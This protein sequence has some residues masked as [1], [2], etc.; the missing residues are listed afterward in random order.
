MNGNEQTNQPSLDKSPLVQSDTPSGVSSPVKKR[1]VKKAVRKAVRKKV[2]IPK[3]ASAK[4]QPSKLDRLIAKAR[5]MY[6]DYVR[7]IELLEGSGADMSGIAN[8]RESAGQMVD[9]IGTSAEL[10]QFF[11]ICKE[12]N[13][14]LGEIQN[15]FTTD[16]INAL[17]GGVEV[18]ETQG[19]D[20]K[21]VNESITA[22]EA[23]VGNVK[24][25]SKELGAALNQIN[26]IRLWIKA[27]IE[28][29]PET[30]EEAVTE[31]ETD[32]EGDLTAD[33]GESFAE[34]VQEP[35]SGEGVL[36][37][38]EIAAGEEGMAE[39]KTVL[40]EQEEES[41]EETAEI[42]SPTPEEEEQEQKRREM[43]ELVNNAYLNIQNAQEEN[44]LKF[45]EAIE[46]VERAGNLI[47]T[48]NYDDVESLLQMVPLSIDTEIELRKSVGKKLEKCRKDLITAT[49]QGINCDEL[50]LKF[51][52]A[53]ELF[54]SS[55][56]TKANVAA[57]AMEAEIAKVV[58]DFNQTVKKIE[59]V[60]A[61][62]TLARQEEINVSE[63]IG[64]FQFLKSFMAAGEYTRAQDTLLVVNVAIMKKRKIR[65]MEEINQT[66]IIL[67]KAPEYIDVKE[68][69]AI[70]D[71]AA[72]ELEE[73]EIDEALESVKESKDLSMSIREK[74]LEL[75][76]KSNAISSRIQDLSE[77]DI[78][79][80]KIIE[81][82]SIGKEE[83]KKGDF[84]LCSEHF[85][86]ALS[87]IDSLG[88]EAQNKN[89]GIIIKDLNKIG[90]E[91]SELEEEYPDDDISELV[92]KHTTLQERF[93]EA[94]DLDDIRNLKN[95]VN[96]LENAIK[97]KKVELAKLAKKKRERAVQGE[98][99]EKVQRCR[100]LMEDIG[101][102]TDIENE[103]RSV[104][105]CISTA[106]GGDITTG[107]SSINEIYNKL[108]EKK[109]DLDIRVEI[110]L[111]GI[112]FE[113]NVWGEAK[114]KVGNVGSFPI[115]GLS[116]GLEGPF[117]MR[118]GISFDRLE[119][120]DIKTGSVAI[121]FTGVGRIP[122]DITLDFTSQPD[123]V[124]RH[125]SLMRWAEVNKETPYKLSM[126]FEEHEKKIVKQK[127]AAII[128]EKPSMRMI[129]KESRKPIKISPFDTCPV[130][131]SPVE[132]GAL[133][134]LCGCAQIYHK[135]CAEKVN[136]NSCLSCGVALFENE[137]MIMTSCSICHM[138]VWHDDEMIAHDCGEYYHRDCILAAG[139]CKNCYAP[140]DSSTGFL[141]ST[142][143]V[144]LEIVKDD[145]DH[146]RCQCG[147]AY[148]APC[149]GRLNFCIR[150][151]TNRNPS[152][153][154]KYPKV[155]QKEEEPEQIRKEEKESPVAPIVA[156]SIKPAK[157]KQEM[158]PIVPEVASTAITAAPSTPT[159]KEEEG[160][161]EKESP[162]EAESSA[163]VPAESSNGGLDDDLDSLLD[164]LEETL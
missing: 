159:T 41:V 32:I 63:E 144:C 21:P 69:L 81:E 47:S 82:Y 140:V 104:R 15:T 127:S 11:S 73:N 94:E 105:E 153:L 5:N 146:Q 13:S 134:Y 143:M 62:V 136:N 111:E 61:N 17:K 148:H 1:A 46:M 118:R 123:G 152:A 129:P 135:K 51:T 101:L 115:S 128:K 24:M 102:Q 14:G 19:K 90:A 56:F 161:A 131:R 72:S 16:L 6:E 132:K 92:E 30:S 154:V 27:E 55:D 76:E 155:I 45:S 36:P 2:R 89:K 126:E 40:A 33:E 75:V 48:G 49:Q 158:R 125:K 142:C 22:E 163:E 74:Y 25:S 98:F 78:D 77:F 91:L 39:E 106:Q 164:D 60:K 147:E 59:E 23:A 8:N 100:M 71:R 141:L 121:K 53:R 9:S 38:T 139:T 65:V 64:K 28:S 85:E 133:K 4:P 67:G 145:D 43:A 87:V 35:I 160:S 18:L 110:S 116:V 68:P 108:I 83:L 130:C 52:A 3:G 50:K 117:E 114:V 34:T 107:L 86:K 162:K 10:K 137:N 26:E 96:G 66:K 149:Y 120:Q 84:G 79:P 124:K 12:L 119:P 109:K 99:N 93:E 103:K 95:S 113:L 44:S 7:K 31:E 80:A 112:G 58:D 42:A 97:E 54:D 88:E 151:G 70:L 156:E 122:V 57:T 150:C 138:D 20:I 157:V 29:V 37:Q